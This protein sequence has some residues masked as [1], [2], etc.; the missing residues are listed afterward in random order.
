MNFNKIFLVIIFSLVFNGCAFIVSRVVPVND[1][2]PPSGKYEIGTQ[3]F[4]W[5]DENRE[6]WFSIKEE[7]K[8]ELMVQVWYPS[9]EPNNS[10]NPY[11]WIDNASLREEAIMENFKVPKFVAKAV[12]RVDTETYLNLTPILSEKFPIV[13]FSHG[14]EGFRSQNTT[15]IQ[16]LVSNGYIVFALDHTY[17]ATLTIMPDGRL[18]PNAKKYCD[19]CEPEEFYEVFLPQINTRINDIKF[20][21]N[22]VEKINNGNI[23]TNFAKALDIENIGVF[24]HSFGGGT[25][26]AT[27]I[28]DSRIKSCI[29]LDGWYVP[30]HPD[31]YNQGLKIPFLHLG[32]VE[33]D[34]PINYEILDKIL[35]TKVTQAYKLSL[36]GASHMDF[37]DSPH[38]SKLSSS[39]NLS[40]GLDSE[41]ILKVTNTTVVGFFD[42]HLK[43]KNTNWLVE[44]RK[45]INTKVEEFQGDK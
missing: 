27:S 43:S 15:Q 21:L 29:S 30:V 6:E 3:I 25:S 4:H 1:I 45:N 12:N 36:D 39:F 26:L 18:I 40:S 32:Q 16:E 5:I 13:I 38:I 20:I 31:I 10:T 9:L 19:G 23:K 17:D 44:L 7:D 28:L 35:D 2:Q 37:T 11:P 33:W 22:Q 34:T 41:E 8:R 14:F 24:G 42:E